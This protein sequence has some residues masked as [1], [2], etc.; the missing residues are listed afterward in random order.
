MP[1]KGLGLTKKALNLSMT[2]SLEQ[3]LVVEE[4]LQTQAGDSYDFNEGCSAFLE[5]RKPVFKGE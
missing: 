2:N 4:D 5:K 3:Q 1:T